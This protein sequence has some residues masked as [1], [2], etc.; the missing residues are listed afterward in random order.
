MFEQPVD[1]ESH[2]GKENDVNTYELIYH[3]K[4][5]HFA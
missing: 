1:E 2:Q 5:G 4:A 3:T